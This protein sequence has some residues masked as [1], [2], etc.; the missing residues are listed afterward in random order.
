MLRKLIVISALGIVAFAAPARAGIYLSS[1][2]KAQSLSLS[3]ST[4]DFS[5][6]KMTLVGG[7]L[8][9]GYAYQSLLVGARGQL[10]FIGQNEAPA[11]LDGTNLGGQSTD[12]GVA[13]GWL[14]QSFQVLFFYDISSTYKLDQTNASN[15]EV[16]YQKPFKVGASLRYLMTPH[17]WIGA[18]YSQAEYDESY[19]ADVL[20]PSAGKLKYQSFGLSLGLAL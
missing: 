12:L 14:F 2:L 1:G 3:S 5:D 11:D 15:Q 18:E 20:Q 9:L 17:W 10:S 19:A 8:I 7:E 4:G 16:T 6:R 13:L